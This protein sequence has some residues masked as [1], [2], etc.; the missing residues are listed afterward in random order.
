MPSLAEIAGL[1]NGILG[2]LFSRFD[3]AKRSLADVVRDPASVLALRQGQLE[4]ATRAVAGGGV[5]A[6]PSSP[7]YQQWLDTI[8]R[9]GPGLMGATV[10][11][12]SP[13]VFDKFDLSKAG[14][15][16]DAGQLGRGIYFSTDKRA[17]ASS[18]NVYASDVNM[19]S[20]LRIEMPDFYTDKTSLIRKAL[21]L[22][23]SATAEDVTKAAQARGHDGVILDYS[24]TGYQHQEYAVF[25]PAQVKILSRE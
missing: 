1:P 18:P 13:H 21:G 14:S 25:D 4:D 2:A 7:E 20:P 17:A 6:D 10:Y 19:S 12:G 16:T 9:M 8:G 3:A 5:L 22:P 24:P 15:T 23:K 11:H